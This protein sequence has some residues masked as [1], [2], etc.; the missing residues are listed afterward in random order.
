MRSTIGFLASAGALLGVLA[1]C[2]GSTGGGTA[3]GPVP[4][5][6]GV[7]PSQGTV[8]TELTISGTNF[9]SGAAVRVGSYTSS[10]VDVAGPTTIYASVP[11]GVTAGQIYDVIVLNSDGTD[12]RRTAAFTA[13][14]PTLLYVN[15]AT[16][17]SGNVGNTVILEGIAFGDQQGPGQV[18][19]SDGAGGTIAATIADPAADWT[20]GFI[21]TTVPSGAATGDVLVQTGT[22]TSNALP[23]TVTANAQFSPSTIA[24]TSTTPLPVGLSGH[25]ATFAAVQGAGASSN[26]VYVTGGAANDYAPR[27][28]VSYSVIQADGH[29]AAWASTAPLPAALAFHAAVAA[30]PAN[31]RVKGTGYIYVLGGASDAAGTP[32]SAIYRGTLAEDGSITS[33][34][35][36]GQLPAAAHSLGAALFRGDLYIVGGSGSANTPVS[37]VY[38]ARLDSLG[39]LGSWQQQLDLPA[40]RTYH[41]VLQFG[42]H[43]YAFG[44]ETA[45]VTPNDA[46]YT[47]NDS[48]LADIAYARI[49]LRTGDLA[50]SGWVVNSSNLFKATSKHTAVAVGG[51]VL[52]T[53]GLYNAANTGSTEESYAQFNSDGSVG[54]FNGATGSRTIVSAGGQNLFNHAAIAY[55]DANG[56]AHVLVLGGDDV[57]APG[58]KRAEIWFY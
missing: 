15:G 27:T 42:G 30:T 35:N 14:A 50:T 31:S 29:L 12:A 6:T 55:V 21:L 4:S 17:P 52:V 23:F 37:T 46:N 57:N 2:G 16:K 1:A 28:D 56:V 5:I 43:L 13:V 45:A 47:N 41:G 44:G 26:I 22:G 38:R 24:W 33:W 51:N 40:G 3:P 7:S 10:A 25:R 8:G 49:S 34:T 48:K 53:A 11:S 19:F 32:T 18:L 20:D 39:A 58:Q 36:A 54:S 9:R